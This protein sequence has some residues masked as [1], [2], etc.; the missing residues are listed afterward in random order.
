MS[1][2]Q[3]QIQNKI[4]INDFSVKFWEARVFIKLIDVYKKEEQGNVELIDLIELLDILSWLHGAMSL[5]DATFLLNQYINILVSLNHCK[6]Y[7][8]RE[9]SYTTVRELFELILDYHY[10]M[11]KIYVNAGISDV[12]SLMRLTIK[13]MLQTLMFI[14][15]TFKIADDP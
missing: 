14:I 15:Q 8:H 1:R 9:V 6:R 13:T 5:K 10:H 7:G 3:S 2:A 4:Q 11:M 12:Y